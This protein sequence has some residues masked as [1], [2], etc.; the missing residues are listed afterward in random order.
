MLLSTRPGITAET[1]SD[2]GGWGCLIVF[3]MFTASMSAYLW[4][5][6]TELSGG[7]LTWW[8]AFGGLLMSLG[9]FQVIR[10][11]F[12]RS[13]GAMLFGITLLAGAFIVLYSYA[14]SDTQA[15]IRSWLPGL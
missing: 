1:P 8:S 6:E 11:V 9:L 7:A 2:I 3:V 13:G 15:L 10:G 12:R 14:S 5:L 4:L